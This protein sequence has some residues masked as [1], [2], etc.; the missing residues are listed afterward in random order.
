MNS[1]RYTIYKTNKGWSTKEDLNE[2]EY[3]T[4]DLKN[5]YLSIND[6]GTG[7]G[8]IQQECALFKNTISNHYIVF[9][10]TLC[11]G[12]SMKEVI[13]IFLYKNSLL[14]DITNSRII[15]SINY[16]HF[17]NTIP[18][19]KALTQLFSKSKYSMIRYSLPRYGTT[20]IATIDYNNIES[21]IDYLNEKKR[22]SDV[23]HLKLFTR[24][25]KSYKKNISIVWDKENSIFSIKNN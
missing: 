18:D 24:C 19:S 22:F 15:P 14:E 20:I 4:V 21:N 12:I 3:L 17:C 6:E 13:V 1:H 10:Q 23:N 11:D 16:K 8:F 25:A 9:A 2:K 7:G 5:G